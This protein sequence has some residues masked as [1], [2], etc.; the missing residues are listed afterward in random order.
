MVHVSAPTARAM[1]ASL[2]PLAL[3]AATAAS[4][5]AHAGPPEQLPSAGLGAT[6]SDQADV[7]FR[8]GN[9]LYKQEKYGD[10]EAAYR[11]A[12]D[13]KKTHDIASNLGHTCMKIGKYRD[14]AELYDF[15]LRHHPPTVTDAEKKRE[16]VQRGL[17]D[18]AKHVGTLRL[19]VEP[20]GAEVSVDGKVVGTA[21]LEADVFVDA[22][23]H[24]VS[25]KAGSKTAKQEVD[26]T[27]GSVQELALACVEGGAKPAPTPAAGA[28]PPKAT[29]EPAKAASGDDGPSVGLIVAGS[30]LAVAGLAAGGVFTGLANGKSSDMASLRSDLGGNTSACAG[31]ASVGAKCNELSDARDGAKMFTNVAVATFVVGGV[32]A[33]ATLTYALWPRG[34][35]APKKAGWIAAPFVGPGTGGLAIGGSL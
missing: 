7:L 25:A 21:P 3:A 15:A 20:A 29:T 23:H 5:P 34:R 1:R 28:T 32:A 19:R 12:W 13:L 17:A 11:A 8:K 2:V 22:G 4:S 35:G 16:F 26:A 18:A 14:A 10:A 30:A 24:T 33:A 9:D 31:V 27:R 6:S